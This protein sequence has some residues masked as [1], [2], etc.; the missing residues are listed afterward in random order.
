MT[1]GARVATVAGPARPLSRKGQRSGV[2]P[3]K[4]LTRG[5]VFLPMHALLLDRPGAP[6]SLCLGERPTPEPRPGQARIRVEACALNPVDYQLAAGGHP[7][8]SWPHIPG[9]DVAGTVEAIGDGVTGVRPGQRVAYHGDLRRPGGLAEYTLADVT[10]LATVPDELDAVTAAAV[11]CAGMAAYQAVVRRMH[12]ATGDT[13][14]VTGGSGGVGGFA[15][16]LAALAGARV[17]ATAAAHNADYV[18]RLGADQ[19][20]DYRNE[21]IT[22]RVRELTDGRGVDAIVDAVGAD[23]ATAHLPLLVHGG[24]M[25]TVAG[26]PDLTTMAPFTIAPS[27]HEIALG[28]A[29]SHGDFRARRDLSTMLAELLNHV[30]Q[31]RLDP[32]LTRTISLEEAPA[33]LTELTGRHVRGK[34]VTALV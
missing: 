8:W 2:H 11:P 23:S 27:V 32:M 29:Y 3:R 5:K 15:V 28:S 24:A 30:A 13:V 10:T 21:D 26:R 7:D 16:Q 33:A 9:L 19:V 25:A 12:V 14:L 6:D 31:G 1:H 20:I 17:I 34:L 22:T 18:R 4:T